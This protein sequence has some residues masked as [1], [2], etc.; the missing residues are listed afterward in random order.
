MSIY[1]FRQHIFIFEVWFEPDELIQSLD[2]VAGYAHVYRLC[3]G[4]YVPTRIVYLYM[5]RI[6]PSSFS[7]AAPDTAVYLYRSP[8]DR[9][10]PLMPLSFLILPIHVSIFHLTTVIRT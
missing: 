7:V 6:R 3:M 10:S 9:C 5:Y 4:V 2:P 1:I 8:T